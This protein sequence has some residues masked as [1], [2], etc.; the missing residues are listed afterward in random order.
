[1]VLWVA[2][3]WALYFFHF[4][5]GSFWWVLSI[6]LSDLKKYSNYCFPDWKD[7]A[8]SRIV[9]YMTFWT[10]V[11]LNTNL[12]L[13]PLQFRYTPTLS[14][15]P[16]CI[17]PWLFFP[18]QKCNSSLTTRHPWVRGRHI[19]KQVCR[20]IV[21]GPPGL[22][23]FSNTEQLFPPRKQLWTQRKNCVSFI[24]VAYNNGLCTVTYVFKGWGFLNDLSVICARLVL[25]ARLWVL[26]SRTDI[27]K[28]SLE[29][30]EVCM[31]EL[32]QSIPERGIWETVNLI[33]TLHQRPWE[34]RLPG[35]R[36][37]CWG[38]L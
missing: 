17:V 14:T 24:P 7:L 8:F 2:S 13:E 38:K 19:P 11:F 37:I 18:V 28:D 26:A 22:L 12:V 36:I 5:F 15:S 3:H 32:Q 29:G 33:P 6:L 31:Q 9:S 23:S 25:T 34:V 35:T 21:W 20:A 16:V 1:M 27:S 30:W 4:Q 10:S